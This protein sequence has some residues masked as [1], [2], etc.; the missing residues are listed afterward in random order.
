[1]N[2]SI[3]EVEAFEFKAK[4]LAKKLNNLTDDYDTDFVDV[5]GLSDFLCLDQKDMKSLIYYLKRGEIIQTDISKN[6]IKL[7]KY[8]KMIYCE[9]HNIAF[10]P[11]VC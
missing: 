7:T 10:A 5:D 1:M 4:R 3:P 2:F 11:I 8:G 9:N 6:Y